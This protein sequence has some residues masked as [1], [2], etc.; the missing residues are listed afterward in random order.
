MGVFPP[1]QHKKKT[2]FYLKDSVTV[3]SGY[4][5][6][7]HTYSDLV[8]LN[9]SLFSFLILFYL[10]FYFLWANLSVSIPTLPTTF[11]FFFLFYKFFLLFWHFQLTCLR[12]ASSIYDTQ[13]WHAI[14]WQ[15]MMSVQSWV[16]QKKKLEIVTGAFSFD[17]FCIGKPSSFAL[18]LHR[19]SSE[20]Q[21]QFI[22]AHYDWG[23]SHFFNTHWINLAWCVW[24]V[25]VRHQ[26]T[27]LYRLKAL[28]YYEPDQNFS[29]AHC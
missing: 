2:L 4:F 23:I 20:L 18:L 5:G 28:N 9:E 26:L 17:V 21:P 12:Q 24:I 6:S 1:S 22:F 25:M 7:Q 29:D 16:N 3:L 11:F 13:A 15:L 8:W 10:K 19:I 14:D 27:L